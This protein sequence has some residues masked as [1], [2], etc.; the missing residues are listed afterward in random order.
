MPSV[1]VSHRVNEFG[2]WKE[3]FDADKSRR[4][5]A[6]ISD[7]VVGRKSEDPNLIYLVFGVDDLSVMHDF[8][9]DPATKA[10]MAEAGV[11]SEPEA[12]FLD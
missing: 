1:I 11:I 6:G 8:V 2:A 10:I 5:A 12:V 9:A 7:L 3:K 4:E